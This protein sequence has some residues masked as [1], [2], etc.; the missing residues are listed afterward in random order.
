MVSI[1]CIE[2][3]TVTR[4]TYIDINNEKLL[5]LGQY[6]NDVCFIAYIITGEE[7]V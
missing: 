6:K 4:Q 1:I 2:R 3:Y 5:D 7:Q